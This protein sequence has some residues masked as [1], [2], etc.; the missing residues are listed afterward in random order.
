V[1]QAIGEYVAGLSG[2]TAVNATVY[3]PSREAET[4]FRNEY[5]LQILGKTVQVQSPLNGGHQQRNLALAIAAAVE[6]RN[7]RSYK[8]EAAAILQGIRETQWPGRLE[9]L[10]AQ[11]RRPAVLLDVAHNAAGAWT[12]RAAL[13]ALEREQYAQWQLHKVLLFG[14]L[15]DK[16]LKELAQILFTAF[17]DESGAGAPTV[18]LT[19]PSSPRA[20]GPAQL[21]EFAATLGIRAQIVEQPRE[22]LQTALAAIPH[23]GLLVCAGS[24]YLVGELRPLLLD[25]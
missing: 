12:L 9:L 23:D 21:A 22:A 16:P 7:Q 18:F 6:L 8:I 13:S 10:P 24:V 3:S 4:M 15:A 14:C 5:P 2:V 17:R 20:A 19:R 25:N 1:N 11:P